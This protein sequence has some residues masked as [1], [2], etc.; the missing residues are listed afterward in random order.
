MGVGADSGLEKLGIFVKS[1]NPQGVIARDGRYVF[2]LTN[3]SRY[4]SCLFFRIQIG[5]QIIEVDDHSLVGV[6]H[7]HATSVLKA[8][9]GLVR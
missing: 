8:T 7:T 5:D 3:L 2:F 9:S 1:L 6:T 4:V